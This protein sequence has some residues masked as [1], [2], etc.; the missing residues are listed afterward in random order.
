MQPELC[1]RLRRFLISTSAIFSQGVSRNQLNNR[2]VLLVYDALVLIA[3]PVILYRICHDL[4][5]DSK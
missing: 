1:T 2:Y 3:M 4:F 5:N